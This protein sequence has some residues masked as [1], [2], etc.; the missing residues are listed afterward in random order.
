M[1]RQEDWDLKIRG[2][3][4]TVRVVLDGIGRVGQ[5]TLTA[6]HVL[7]GPSRIGLEVRVESREDAAA[8]TEALISDLM[9]ADWY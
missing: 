7:Y 3:D 5:G 8:K 2:R 4:V 9:G 1:H 6:F